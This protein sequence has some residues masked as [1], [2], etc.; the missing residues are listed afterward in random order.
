MKPDQFRRLALSFPET[1]EKSHMNHPDFR[2]FGKIFATLSYPD[3]ARGMVQLTP[4][5]QE[6]F[7]RAEPEVFS[8]CAGAWGRGGS[9]TVNL[10][11]A[12]KTALKKALEA[13]W[14]LAVAK[15]S[16]KKPSKTPTKQKSA[17]TK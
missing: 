7:M 10:K 14:Q 9:T 16:G 11:A 1:E 8:P 15:R 2:V 12:K 5:E 3:E 13:A 17:S 6:M 4:M